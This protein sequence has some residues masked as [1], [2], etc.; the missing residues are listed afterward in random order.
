MIFTC[1]KSIVFNPSFWQLYAVHEPKI[2][3]PTTTTSK[4]VDMFLF[5]IC[6][7]L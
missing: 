2:P 6:N 7:K 4:S 3:A 1:S 5:L